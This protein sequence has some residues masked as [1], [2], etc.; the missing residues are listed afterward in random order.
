MQQNQFNTALKL[1]ANTLPDLRE[2]LQQMRIKYPWFTAAHVLVCKADHLARHE[3]YEENLRVAAVYVNDREALFD[4]LMKDRFKETVDRFEKELSEQETTKE[5]AAFEMNAGNEYDQ[6]ARDPEEP[7][8]IEPDTTLEEP[9]AESDETQPLSKKDAEAK[10][11]DRQETLTA[12]DA[13]VV[14][15]SQKPETAPPE[16]EKEA[17]TMV[18]EKP[19]VRPEDLDDLQRE[20]VVAAISST[21][22]LEQDE[23]EE[24]VASEESQPNKQVP[25][26]Y[27]QMSPDDKHVAKEEHKT[28]DVN[29]SSLP[30]D[31]ALDGKHSPF[32]TWLL[33]KANEAHWHEEQRKLK[34][35]EGADD[36]HSNSDSSMMDREGTDAKPETNNKEGTADQRSLIDAFIQKDPKITPKKSD[37]FSSENL[38]KMSLVDDEQWV[39]ETMAEVYAAQGKIRKAIKAYKLLSLKYPEKSVYFANR[40]KKLRETGKSN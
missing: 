31:A 13:E 16:E 30:D 15:E 33:N 4:L 6:P 10:N 35:Q 28:E 39:T 27:S 8:S 22:Q 18:R 1:N 23:D 26:A 5:E 25:K 24:E 37:M 34:L 40:I 20:M 12:S 36:H 17:E 11:Q 3:A 21:I 14:P 29:K 32:T 2:P 19:K 7:E 9:S 38:A